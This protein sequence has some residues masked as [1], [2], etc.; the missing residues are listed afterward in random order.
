MHSLNVENQTNELFYMLMACHHESFSHVCSDMHEKSKITNH[1]PQ[2]WFDT[3]LDCKEALSV[4]M[5]CAPVFI[6]VFISCSSTLLGRPCSG[7]SIWLS[8]L[9]IS[10]HF[11]EFI[12]IFSQENRQNTK[13]LKVFH[14]R[15]IRN[16]MQSIN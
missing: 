4:L 6:H 10:I 11:S 8:L 2:T 3:K 1:K 14:F 15:V 9:A 12:S 5:L 16:V 7:L 13:I